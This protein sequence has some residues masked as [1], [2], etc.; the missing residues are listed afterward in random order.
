MWL[1]AAAVAGGGGNETTESESFDTLVECQMEQRRCGG[2]VWFGVLL[3]RRNN[4]YTW[5]VSISVARI[6]NTLH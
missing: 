3:W 5:F 6:V 4:A 2:V 1:S